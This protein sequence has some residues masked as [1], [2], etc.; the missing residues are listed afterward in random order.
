[1]LRKLKKGQNATSNKNI[2]V[3]V[4]FQVWVVVATYML[5]T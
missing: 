5:F 2:Y 3:L 4:L 1:L